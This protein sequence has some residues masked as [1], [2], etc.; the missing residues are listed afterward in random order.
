MQERAAASG[1]FGGDWRPGWSGVGA[2][3]EDASQLRMPDGQQPIRFG[4]QNGEGKALSTFCRSFPPERLSGDVLTFWLRADRPL[5]KLQVVLTDADGVGAETSV[6]GLLGVSRL[7]PGKWYYVVW[8][9]RISPGWVRYTRS[10]VDWDRIRELSF[11]TWADQLSSA[12]RVEIG[13]FRVV[14]F[15]ELEDVFCRFPDW[16]GNNRALSWRVLR[17]K[18]DGMMGEYFRRRAADAIHTLRTSWPPGR[19]AHQADRLRRAL[20]A[21]Y[22][23]PAEKAEVASTQ[24]GSFELD[25]VRLEKHLLRLRPGVASIALLLLP[26]PGA[27]ATPG[28]RQP[29]ILMLPGHGDPFWATSF[30]ERC[31]SFARRGWIV[32]AVEPFGQTERG[33]NPRWSESHD[34]QAMAFLLT[35]GQSLMGLIMADHQAEFSWL[36]KHPRVDAERV[37][38][39]GVS[40]GGTHSLWFAALESRARAAVAVAVAPEARANWA[41]GPQGLCDLMVGLFRVA[42]DDLIR[43]LVAPRPFLEICPSVQA[44]LSPQGERRCQ[45]TIGSAGYAEAVKRYPL[46]TDDIRALHPLARQTYALLRADGRYGYEVIDGPHDYTRSMRERAAGFLAGCWQREGAAGSLPE[47]T[48]API[49]GRKIAREMLDFWPHGQ[50]P[51]DILAPTAY[52][53]REMRTLIQRLPPPA[54]TREAWRGQRAELRQQI[55]ALL[56]TSW[57][58][59]QPA[60]RQ[61]GTFR[62]E[63]GEGRKLVTNSEPG[64]EIPMHL[65]PPADGVRPDGRLM[66]F[67]D[68]AGMKA[69]SASAERK[70]RTAAGA[71]VLCPDLRSMGETHFNEQGAYLGFRDLDVGI[72]SLKLGET[73]AGYWLRDCLTAIAV[74][75]KAA[76]GGLKV[77]I[78][79]EDETGLIALLAAIAEDDIAA[80]ETR[81]FLASY[82]S[83]A[84]YGLPFAYCDENNDKSVRDRKLSG[85]GSILPCIP[86]ILKHADIPQ[87]MA[88]VAPRPLTVIEPKWASGE[89][90]PAKDFAAAFASTADVYALYGCRPAL[91]VLAKSR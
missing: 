64:I 48:L 41:C 34:T 20:A 80:V 37:A 16:A 40:M 32:M 82:Y 61:V 54:K 9:F 12:A 6:L 14:S 35:A 47:A 28:G 91:R 71:W 70:R 65:F 84:G 5:E 46:T 89:S 63:R 38:V 66:V 1:F 30:Q 26:R 75:Q 62:A 21:T 83:A 77:T 55:L 17:D 31:L 4:W 60:W 53:Q 29:T 52:V 15:A 22:L 72:A 33:E 67:L 23:M 8:P 86:S 42:D 44:P 78:R 59:R 90:L 57:G 11:Y 25:G 18:R 27:D 36:L 45:C 50:R 87:I 69:T 85:Y 39:T 68:P 2:R 56:G 58:V 24:L 3:A 51:A 81:G 19:V 43:A 49:R 88:L 76:G 13:S 73:L 79:G 10:T 7:E 74:A